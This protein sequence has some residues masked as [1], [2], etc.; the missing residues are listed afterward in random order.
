MAKRIKRDKKKNNHEEKKGEQNK[1]IVREVFE[2]NGE[3]KIVEAE[4]KHVEEPVDEKTKGK[5]EK[6]TKIVLIFLGIAV[7]TIV[8]TYFIV[9][10]MNYFNYGGMEFAK[11]KYFDIN[12]YHAKI[13]IYGEQ[14]NVL[15][16]TNLF[17]RNDPRKLKGIN[18]EG[19][20]EIF[21]SPILINDNETRSCSD[22][23]I[24]RGEFELFAGVLGIKNVEYN[25]GLSCDNSDA[26]TVLILKNSNRNAITQ[27]EDK[28][29]YVLE[30]NSCDDSLKVYER[31]MLISLAKVN[32][33]DY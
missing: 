20:L 28:S 5:E 8:A 32:G 1:D 23:S 9:S 2:V 6:I 30:F 15:S 29:C 10:N 27:I 17:F 21:S 24:N 14:K 12:F 25:A 11:E 33:A 13:P 3:E 26:N 31:F 18:F 22:N 4:V 7:L 16:Y 19:D